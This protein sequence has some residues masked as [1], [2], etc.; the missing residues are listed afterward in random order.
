VN[1]IRALVALESGV[2]P[3]TVRAVL[4]STGL[5]VLKWLEAGSAQQVARETSADLLIV[6]CSARS[7][8]S[9]SLIER[10]TKLAPEQPIVVLQLDG[11]DSN[12]FMQQVFA[13]GADDI[14]AM[15]ET[16]ERIRHALQK[17]IARKRGAT[18]SQGADPASLVCVLGPKGGTGK[19]VTSLNLAVALAEQGQRVCLADLDLLFGDV[20]LGLRLTPE[21]T[22]YDLARAGG[23]LDADK[24][25]DYLTDHASGVRTLLAPTRPDHA[26]A[27]RSE[28]VSEVLALLRSMSDFVVVDTPA[29]FSSEVITAVDSSTDIC[30][31]GMLDAFSLKDTRL[32]LE[33][34]DRMGYDRDSI[35]VILNR[36]DTYVG[37]SKD[38]V[39]AI[40]EREPDVLVPSQ[41]D[42]PRTITEGT[43]IVMAQP[44]STA[45]KAFRQLASLYIFTKSV[46]AAENGAV[47]AAEP[48][49][50][51]LLRRA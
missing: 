36:A 40:L 32:G 8:S 30:V 2:S 13:A 20:G 29:G 33:T 22:I 38:D 10:V 21:R 44:K 51:T 28:F 25:G 49:L 43:P 11:A 41:R 50:K 42:I 9:I 34:L 26:G 14:V 4:P 3:E 46:P 27:V 47:P 1:S 39:A 31:V 19:T 18:L 5:E 45:A 37:I 23:T 48:R 15:P 6:A 24:V 7:G 35:R 16:P 17:A 12:G